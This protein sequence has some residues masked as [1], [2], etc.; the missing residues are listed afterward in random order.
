MALPLCKLKH[1]LCSVLVSFPLPSPPPPRS[2]PPP[3]LLHLMM[4]RDQTQGFTQQRM[5][6]NIVARYLASVLLK[7]VW[8]SYFNLKNPI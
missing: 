5:C 8:T 3:W 2:S 4:P 7:L 1:G 6:L